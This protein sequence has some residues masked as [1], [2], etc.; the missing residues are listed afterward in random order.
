M[1]VSPA[2]NWSVPEAEWAGETAFV[3]G[4]GPSLA[5]APVERLD[6]RR[7]IAV[8]DV[9]LTRATWAD[10]LFFADRRW[11]D[12]N[13]SE[14]HRHTGRWKVTRRAPHVETGCDVKWLYHAPALK[15]SRDPDRVS[16]YCG[17]AMAI[18]IAFLLG[19]RRIV[20]MG[21]DQRPG[22]WHDRHKLPAVDHNYE[23]RFRPALERMAVE[24]AAEGVECINAT[25]GSAL[26]CFPIVEPEDVLC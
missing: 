11:L 18:N 20:L 16:G 24:L 25:P 9:G 5:Q 7:V 4:G 6:G 12:W 22:S 21:F 19:A 10:V 1:R 23:K 15:L 2:P 26:T 8:N 17:G 13:A 3:L 14:L